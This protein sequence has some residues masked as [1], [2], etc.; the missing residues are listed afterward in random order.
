MTLVSTSA[1]ASSGTGTTQY[2]YVERTT[3]LTAGVEADYIVGNA[4]TYDG[5]TRIRIELFA[6]TTSLSANS[7]VIFALYD[8]VTNKGRF[9]DVRQDGGTGNASVGVNASRFLTPS[10]GAHTF[11]I[12]ATKAG[13]GS[14]TVNAGDGSGAGVYVP[15]Y[16]RITSA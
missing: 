2:D 1:K 9:T 7:G 13:T 5:A 6:P 8:G 11:K 15:A 14:V 3:D 10:A 16:L 12:T 4:V